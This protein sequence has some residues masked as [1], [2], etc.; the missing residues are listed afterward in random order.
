[1]GRFETVLYDHGWSLVQHYS[2]KGSAYLFYFPTFAA[3]AADMLALSTALPP[4]TLFRPC[5]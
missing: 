3:K 1:M 4:S 5:G 2:A